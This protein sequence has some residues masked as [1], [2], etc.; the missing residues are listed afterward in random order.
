M[1]QMLGAGGVELLVDSAR[2][3]DADNPWGYCE[4]EPVKRLH[5]DAAFLRDADGKAVKVIHALV[6]AIP[7]DRE[8]RF[9]AMRRDLAAVVASQQRMLARRSAPTGGIPEGRLAEILMAQLEEALH[10]VADQ[11][12]FSLLEVDYADVLRDA[13]TV[14]E[15]VD[16]FLGGGLDPVAMAGCIHRRQHRLG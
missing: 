13:R 6:T 15:K 9:V 11:P 4:Y 12:R 3:A 10:W 16:A 7:S 2:S 5:R 8:V 14:A 1:M